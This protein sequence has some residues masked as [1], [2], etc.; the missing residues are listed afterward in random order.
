MAKMELKNDDVGKKK[1]EGDRG[2]EKERER[3]REK[4]E[5]RERKERREER[6]QTLML[7]AKIEKYNVFQKKKGLL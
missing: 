3:E 6:P 2:T 7:F 4:T 5:R 1:R